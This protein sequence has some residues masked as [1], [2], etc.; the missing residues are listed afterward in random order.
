MYYPCKVGDEMPTTCSK[1]EKTS[2]VL[3]SVYVYGFL[4]V[5]G[6]VQLGETSLA[7][8]HPPKIQFL[9]IEFTPQL[10]SLLYAQRKEK[11]YPGSNL[12]AKWWPAL[13]RECKKGPWK[14]LEEPLSNCQEVLLTLFDLI[15]FH[16]VFWGSKNLYFSKSAYFFDTKQVPL[17]FCCDCHHC[18]CLRAKGSSEDFTCW[19]LGIV[20]KQKALTDV[21]VSF[22]N[23]E[24]DF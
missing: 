21:T 3:W 6:K 20:Q 4:Y 19:S 18:W 12:T 5:I 13:P 8:K 23:M 11:K 14:L 2:K 9:L 1:T 10:W 7:K 15:S 17:L 24:Q 22:H 16:S